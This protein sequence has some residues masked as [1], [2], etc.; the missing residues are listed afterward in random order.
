MYDCKLFTMNISKIIGTKTPLQKNLPYNSQKGLS[1][2][3]LLVAMTITMLVIVAASSVYLV[4]RQGFRSND[5]STRSLE[6]GRFAIDILTRNIR[7]AGAYNFNM[8]DNLGAYTFPSGGTV[9][10]IFGVEGGANPDSIVV[11]YESN[12]PF[13]AAQLTGSDCLGQSVGTGGIG[14]VVNNF[15]ISADG[16]LQCMGNGAPGVTIPIVG[17][18]VDMQIT[19]NVVTNAGEPGVDPDPDPPR[20]QSVDASAI[21]DW[22]AV[23]AANICVDVAS[24]DVGTIEGASPGLNCRGVAF[25]ADRRVHRVYR[26]TVNIRNAT[27]GGNFVDPISGRAYP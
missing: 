10:P 20:V 5:D 6:N 12:A 14:M 25:A 17:P 7:M 24:F 9:Q 27:R 13:N 4:A 11:S 19:Y 16:Q 3:E 15:S 22:S 21:T 8:A 18:V 2:I 23:R 1:L 26:T